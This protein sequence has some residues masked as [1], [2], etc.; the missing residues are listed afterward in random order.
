MLKT[1]AIIG[2]KIT[3]KLA[4]LLG[5]GSA[6]PGL[7]LEKLDINAMVSD[8][9]HLPYGVIVVSGTNG[10]TSTTKFLTEI[11]QGQGLKVFTN[12]SGSN[13]VRGVAS[14]WL[15]ECNLKGKCGADIAVLELDEA[16]AI[17]FTKLVKIN[18]ALLLNVMRDQLDRFG[19][20]DQVA[21]LLTKIAASAQKKVIVNALDSHLENIINSQNNIA[22]FGA[23]ETIQG[24]LINIDNQKNSAK[25]ELLACLYKSDKSG[26]DFNLNC[27]NHSVQTKIKGIYNHYNIT[28]AIAASS[29]ILEDKLNTNKLC[30]SINK[31]QPAFGRAENIQI[32][33][34][35]ITLFLVKNPSGFQSSLN[36]DFEGASIMIAINDEYA[37]GR[38]VSWL[39]DV[40][41]NNLAKAESIYCSGTRCHDMA[42]RLKYDNITCKNASTDYKQIIAEQLAND[43]PEKIIFS[44]YT[45]MLAIRKELKR[46]SDDNDT[47]PLS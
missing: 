45:A 34:K 13:F 14:S 1:I 44:T 18:Y 7:V 36:S 27:Q 21:D 33:D 3:H 38:D 41:F 5:G 19:E 32:K 12:K 31:L 40:G 46:L 39:W 16:H 25:N 9:E 17:H 22:L 10:K 24:Q 20:L 4:A 15:K 23:N 42:L 30:Q 35:E 43:N 8:L 47:S 11:L 28:A 6:M 26:F 2:G 37:D 29:V